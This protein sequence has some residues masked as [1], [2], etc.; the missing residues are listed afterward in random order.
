[1]RY[2]GDW[3]IP[4]GCSESQRK[5]IEEMIKEFEHQ[6][7]MVDEFGT[8]AL[9]VWKKINMERGYAKGRYL[10]E[11]YGIKGTDLKAVEELVNAY[12]DDDPDRTAKPKVWVVDEKLFVESKGFCPLIET[13]KI[14]RLDMSYTCPYSTRPYFHAMCR[15]VNPKVMHRNTKWRAEGDEV[16]QEIFWIEG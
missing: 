9:L 2:E 13:A 12:L 10:I 4:N 7:A 1:M 5:E 16:C 3:E 6:F 14:L 11:K 8:K 15:A